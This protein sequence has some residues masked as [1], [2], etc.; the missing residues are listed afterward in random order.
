MIRYLTRT[1]KGRRGLSQSSRAFKPQLAF[2]DRVEELRPLFRPGRRREIFDRAVAATNQRAIAALQ[3]KYSDEISNL[4]AND[5]PKYLD[6][7]ASYLTHSRVMMQ[8]DLDRRPPCSI[9]DI[10]AGGGRFLAMAKCYGH[11]VLALDVPEPRLYRDLEAAL[12]VERVDGG[13]VFGEAL[14]P[15]VGKLD[16]I[17]INNQVFDVHRSDMT[18]WRLRE[19]KALIRH[20]CIEHL[21]MP[22]EIFVG[23]NRTEQSADG[24]ANF[25]GPFLDFAE[26]VGATVDRNYGTSRFRFTH[27]PDF[28]DSAP[29]SLSYKPNGTTGGT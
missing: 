25:Y 23:L 26:S 27:V 28:P 21:Q 22:G 10:G 3:D 17:V 12:G 9:L 1:F 13:I 7:A 19:W 5:Y 16:L 4:P 29:W 20:L 18:R 2:D 24:L 15:G 11:R 14:P 8:L 6:V